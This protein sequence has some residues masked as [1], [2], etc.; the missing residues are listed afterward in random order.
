MKRQYVRGSN[1]SA[2]SKRE[3]P[4]PQKTVHKPEPIY[5]EIPIEENRKFK[6]NFHFTPTVVVIVFALLAIILVGVILINHTD[7][8][9]GPIPSKIVKELQFPL[10]YP[11]QLP[12]GYKVDPSSFIVKDNNVLVFSIDVPS[13]KSI[14]VSEEALP[15]VDATELGPPDAPAGAPIAN[16]MHIT[17]SVGKAIIGIWGTNYVSSLVTNKTWVILNVSGQTA[18]QAS[19]VTASFQAM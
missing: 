7:K 11:N 12:S 6:I 18:S 17:T 1:F 15:D 14:A 9:S 3:V 10:Y 16:N 8:P 13:G 4:N 19:A 2:V 5:E